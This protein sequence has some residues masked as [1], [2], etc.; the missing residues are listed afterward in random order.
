MCICVHTQHKHTSRNFT[1][2]NFS[3][4]LNIFHCKN[5]HNRHTSYHFNTFKAGPS[6]TEFW[7]VRLND[8]NRGQTYT[9]G[10]GGIK[11]YSYVD[12]FYAGITWELK[13]GNAHS[14]TVSSMGTRACQY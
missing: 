1:V 9:F 4:E 7:V 3:S 11:F 5:K 8:C 10:K 2:S 6:A 14:V 13:L 12:D